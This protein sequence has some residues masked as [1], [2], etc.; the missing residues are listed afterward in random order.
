MKSARPKVLHEVAG[1]PMLGHVLSAAAAA[2]AERTV[3]VIAPH[4]SEVAEFVRSQDPAIR[5]AV[6]GT[7]RGTADAVAAA[8]PDLEGIS[9]PVLVL[10]GD[11]PLIRPATLM[12]MRNL[13][14]EG[15]AVV[16]LGFRAA[17]PTG[18]GRLVLEADGMVSA[19]RE[20]ADANDQE[21]S[22][23]LCNAGI[24]GI[25]SDVLDSLLAGIGNKNAKG[26][27]YLTDAVAA[28]GAAGLRTA[29]VECDEEEV[30]GVNDR[31]QLARAEAAMQRRLRTEALAGGVTMIAPET[32]Y[33]SA[34]TKFGCD[35]TIEP[36]V[37]FGPGVAVGS[38]AVIKAFSHIAGARI[39][40]RASIG[41]FARIRPQTTIGEAARVGN[42]VEVKQ[43]AIADGAKVNHL[44]YIGDASV[45]AGANI[46]AGTITC[47]Y[48]GFAKHR[49][50]IGAGAFIGSNSAL[51]A[52]VTIGDGAYVGSGS[53]ITRDVAADALALTRPPAVEK[54]GWA[55]RLREARGRRDEPRPKVD[56]G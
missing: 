3:V 19:I 52:P 46:G 51:V 25:R 47:N 39:G 17:D 1:V 41:P 20:E 35:V 10:Y 28:A 48:D 7:T 23:T 8:R 45:G 37:V 11:T 49:T 9:G 14:D 29:L 33:L 16:V 34:D 26:E 50:E 38:G 36:H 24:M 31:A 4:M 53:V 6:Q 54:P 22:I 2:G 30:L 13:L 42:F 21:R 55:K 44:S 12:R 56:S 40:D 15:V 5:V 27:Y 18:Y 32:V 43:A